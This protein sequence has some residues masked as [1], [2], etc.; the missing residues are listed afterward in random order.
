MQYKSMLIA[1]AVAVLGSA[2]AAQAFSIAASSGCI[3]LE[4]ENSKTLCASDG[5]YELTVSPDRVTYLAGITASTT[6]KSLATAGC[7]ASVNL[8]D[9]S[10]VLTTNLIVATDNALFQKDCTRFSCAKYTDCNALADA[11]KLPL[12]NPYN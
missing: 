10:A 2:G 8:S 3:V 1:A 4:S 11:D 7:R 6:D 12:A 9:N 5:A